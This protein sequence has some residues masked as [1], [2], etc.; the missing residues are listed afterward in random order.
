MIIWVRNAII[1]ATEVVKEVSTVVLSKV[2]NDETI[3]VVK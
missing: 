3:E 1:Q 2:E